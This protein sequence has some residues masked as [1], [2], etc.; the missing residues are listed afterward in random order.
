MVKEFLSFKT[1]S[2]ENIGFCN[3]KKRIVVKSLLWLD[4]K[5]SLVFREADEK[6]DLHC[7]FEDARESNV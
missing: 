3:E 1:E 7:K 5:I 4:Q 2:G 6:I